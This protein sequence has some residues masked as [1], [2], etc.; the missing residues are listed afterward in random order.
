MGK[1][2]YTP[3]SNL[4]LD[5]DNEQP[6]ESIAERNADD[7][8]DESKMNEPNPNNFIVGLVAQSDLPKEKQSTLLDKFSD[9][10]STIT[11][12]SE[13]VNQIVITEIGQVKEQK[14]ARE[15][16]L[17]LKNKR[18]EIENTRKSLKEDI[19]KEGKTIDGISNALK[20]LI[21]PLEEK[22]E[23]LEKY[24]IIHLAEQRE[25]RLA[26]RLVILEQ[27]NVPVDNNV[28]ADMSDDLFS[29]FLDGVK[30]QIEAK[31]K[32]EAEAEIEAQKQFEE[33]QKRQAELE[34]E[35]ARLR[36]EAEEKERLLKLEAEAKEERNAKRSEQMRPYIS[37]IR[38]YNK[39]LNMEDAEFENEL[40]EVDK[41]AKLHYEHE[42]KE[43]A[44]AEAEAKR[45]REEQEA[46][47]EK[48]RAEQAKEIA[49]AKAESERQ[50]LEYEKAQK[51]KE[52][53][54]KKQKEQAAKLKAEADRLKAIA[55]KAEADRLAEIE[56]DEK[57]VAKEQ[58]LADAPKLKL[59]IAEMEVFKLESMKKYTFKSKDGK[60][61]FDN[62]NALIEKTIVYAKAQ[63]KDL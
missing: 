29:Y 41:G 15:A 18:I 58:K 6:S 61:A 35:N 38:D 53:E 4:P 12:W 55:D 56:A 47:L 24:D 50:R 2:T 34:A 14:Q 32:Q 17:F 16:R 27:Y 45:Q 51:I 13:K 22:C 19:V 49:K 11:E 33:E 10:Y 28:I 5:F 52:A 44:K 31:R 40:V 57:R 20:A 48:Q 23:T 8:H 37:F 9:L 43:K 30:G 59:F 62:I 25:Q 26:Q 3:E 42:A 7:K 54:L 36:A 60:K 1:D 63:H 21:E 46:I 39:M